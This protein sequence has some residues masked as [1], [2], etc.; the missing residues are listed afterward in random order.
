MID[1]TRRPGV[2]AEVLARVTNTLARWLPT[3]A[4]ASAV[5]DWDRD[6]WLAAEWVVYWQNALP[7]LAARIRATSAD[8]PDDVR[9]RLFAVDRDSRA[10]TQAML[11]SAVELL[12]ALREAGVEAIPLKG[13]ALAPLYYP[14]PGLRPLADLDLLVQRKDVAAGVEVMKQLGYV[15]YSRSAEDEVYLRGIR[16]AN[17]WA[18]DNVHPV[19]MHYTLR[20]E[21]AGL[22]YELAPAVWSASRRQAYWGGA[23]AR[24][25]D[26]AILL[27]HVCAHA[28]SDWLIQRG[29]VMQIGDVQRIA[30][31]MT[32]ED[33]SAF[34][35]GLTPYGA[36][37]VYPAL[38]LTLRFASRAHPA[39][40]HGLAAPAHAAGDCR[41][42]RSGSS[43]SRRPSRIPPR[44]AASASASRGCW[45]G[46]ASSG[47]GCGC[48]RSSP[49]GGT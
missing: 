36:R 48:A 13:A 26:P 3:D 12:E 33:W 30:A 7:W 1:Y 42:G 29:K 11:A 25:P 37:F 39:G 5:A 28:T 19:E 24:V 41:T 17:V 45:R 27:H 46:R 9:D 20:E 22:A 2:P 44:A 8:V 43:R 34:A 16:K 35:A 14:D 47:A 49:A 15:F 21:Y 4:D 6:A 40:R 31:R 32:G 10:R 18:P 23:Q 38:A